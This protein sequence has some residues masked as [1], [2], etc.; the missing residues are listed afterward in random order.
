MLA[1][2]AEAASFLFSLAVRLLL[3]PLFFF[4]LLPLFSPPAFSLKDLSS[5]VY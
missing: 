1:H 2:F 3:G 5:S 4:F